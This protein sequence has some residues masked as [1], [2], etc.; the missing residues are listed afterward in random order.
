MNSYIKNT[1]L[2]CIILFLAPGAKA[3]ELDST[4]LAGIGKQL[5]AIELADVPEG[6]HAKDH[7][8][9]DKED[10][11]LSCY[12][13]ESQPGWCSDFDGDGITDAL[14][15]FMDE[16]LGGG[17]NAFGYDYRIVLLDKQQ[18]IRK[19]YSIF[20]GG[21]LSYAQLDVNRVAQGKIY[22][23]YE[24][25]Q[26]LR[27]NYEDTLD[28]KSYSLEF[29]LE[30][31]RVVEKHYRNCPLA[32]MKKQLFR[33]DR[34]LQLRSSIES[35]DQYNESCTE[36]ISMPD[37]SHYTAMLEGCEDLN[38]YFSRT[39]AYKKE[40]ESE[41]ELMKKTLL[42]Q[43][44]FLKENTIYKSL[45]TAGYEQLT[46]CPSA[47]LAGSKYGGTEFH[48]E[49]SGGW[50]MHLF[51]SGNKEQGSF[52]TLRFVKPKATTEMDFW[53]SMDSKMKLKSG[54]R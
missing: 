52:L 27:G 50:Q 39:I 4:T 8:I 18:H 37:G 26:F 53:E 3:A 6:A 42:N 12:Y 9:R 5:I 14:F 49:L 29:M 40:L 54:Q 30:G 16:G 15:R 2:L 10:N 34:G 24:E 46:K 17:G 51:I 44:L 38:L 11:F 22:A 20:G 32:A 41:K 7:C 45:M 28:L 13:A 25:N 33:T 23:T 1:V 21:K 48:A 36:S 43:L 35:D 19:Q 31:D 47:K